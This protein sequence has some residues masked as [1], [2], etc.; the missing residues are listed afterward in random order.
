MLQRRLRC[1][2]SVPQD[3]GLGILLLTTDIYQLTDWYC[4]CVHIYLYVY[5]YMCFCVYMHVGIY[6]YTCMC[7]CVQL[8]MSVL[9][10]LACSVSFSEISSRKR[11]LERS[12]NQAQDVTLEAHTSQVSR[13]GP[14]SVSS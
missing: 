2:Y 6:E 14:L 9:W 8:R 10:W 13:Q 11:F 7:L 12:R 5:M 1:L 3:V 4:M